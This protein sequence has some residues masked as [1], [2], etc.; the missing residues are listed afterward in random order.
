MWWWKRK[1]RYRYYIFLKLYF[2]GDGCSHHCTIE[3]GYTCNGAPS[4][5]AGKLF[6]KN[7][8][9]LVTCGDGVIGV[10]AET[11]DDGNIENGDGCSDECLVEHDY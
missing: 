9:T 1:Q 11:C 10:G 4:I 7:I 2:I 3:K 5:C 8:Y 6:I